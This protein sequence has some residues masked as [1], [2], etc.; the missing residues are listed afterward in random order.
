MF[1]RKA[2]AADADR[3]TPSSRQSD[4]WCPSSGRFMVQPPPQNPWFLVRVDRFN[5]GVSSIFRAFG[6]HTSRG[7]PF[8]LDE[9]FGST[10]GA[11]KANRTAPVWSGFHA[12]GPRSARF[13]PPIPDPVVLWGKEGSG[14][15]RFSGSPGGQKIEKNEKFPNDPKSIPVTKSSGFERFWAV[16]G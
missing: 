15:W 1:E 5:M 10:V 13:C 8:S 11:A 2:A 12:L 9:V 3:T 7:A 4:A 14:T 16:F 6:P